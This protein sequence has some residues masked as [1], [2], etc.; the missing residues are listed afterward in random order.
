[1][2]VDSNTRGHVQWFNFTIKNVEKKKIKINIV[3]FRKHKTL[4][5]RVNII[6]EIGS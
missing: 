4:Y 3:N 1:M 2:R 5:H 6:N